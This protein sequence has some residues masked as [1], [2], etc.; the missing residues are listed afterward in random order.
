MKYFLS[1]FAILLSLFTTALAQ[2]QKQEMTEKII[3]KHNWLYAY[4]YNQTTTLNLSESMWQLA[5]GESKNPKGYSTLK[6]MGKAFVD[7]SDQFGGTNLEKKCGFGVNTVDEKDNRSGCKLAIDGW[8]GKYKLTVN[9]ANVQGGND[10]F[11]MVFGYI[12]SVAI[13]LEDGSAAL[14][15]HGYTPKSEKQHIVINADAKY[16]AVSVSWDA[17]GTTC[18]INAPADIETAGWDGKIE[19]GLKAGWKK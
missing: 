18:T 19:N 8:N 15:A 17:A 2:N 7:L 4:A 5:L 11:K 9:A 3:E 16:K 1:T 6:R 12:S 13:Y 10:A 14:W